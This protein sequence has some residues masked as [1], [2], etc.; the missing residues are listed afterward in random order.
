[1]ISG[2]LHNN[3]YDAFLP[4]EEDERLD[5]SDEV[6]FNTQLLPKTFPLDSSANW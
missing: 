4:I 5:I 1:M 3:H 6:C 2:E